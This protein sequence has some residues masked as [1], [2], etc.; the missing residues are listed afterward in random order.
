MYLYFTIPQKS[1]YQ[2][3]GI[4]HAKILL[5]CGNDD[6]AEILL[7]AYKLYYLTKQKKTKG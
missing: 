4:W 3:L 1:C 6:N 2:T 5:T 7:I